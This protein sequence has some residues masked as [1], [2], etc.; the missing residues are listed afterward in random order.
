[1]TGSCGRNASSGFHAYRHTKR[2]FPFGAAALL[3]LAER[4]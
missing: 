1:M 4:G 3:R 2:S